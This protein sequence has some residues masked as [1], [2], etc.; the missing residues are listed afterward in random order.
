[1]RLDKTELAD[2]IADAVNRRDLQ[3]F[4]ALM[5]PEVVVVPR[6]L[7][8]EG[9]ELRGHRGAQAWWDGIFDA[10]PDF[11]L[12]VIED[13]EIDGELGI[14]RMVARGHGKGSGAPF[15]DWFWVASRARAGKVV[16][17]RRCGSEAEA[18]EAAGRSG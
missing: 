15:E 7:A 18:L 3:G 16:W 9:G 11:N 17:W 5:D 14:T 2:R 13:R 10:F 6:I 4:L 12:E 8:V 1:M